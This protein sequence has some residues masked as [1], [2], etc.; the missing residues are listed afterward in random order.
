MA[1][2]LPRHV[3]WRPGKGDVTPYL[4]VD[5]GAEMILTGIATQGGHDIDGTA[6]HSNA[7]WVSK[8]RLSGSFDGVTW[9]DLASGVAGNVDADSA[10]H[11][12]LGLHALEQARARF[13]RLYPQACGALLLA[14]GQTTPTSYNVD[15]AGFMCALRLELFGY[16]VCSS[17]SFTTSSP[18]K[19]AV[20]GP[21]G[22]ENGALPDS[23]ITASS[24]LALVTPASAARLN[25]VQGFFK[26]GGWSPSCPVVDGA[27]AC[28]F[29]PTTSPP[30]YLQVDLGRELE[31][32]AVGT[33]GSS[34]RP[35][36][37]T[38]YFLAFSNDGKH[39]AQTAKEFV[40]NADAS[41]VVKLS[42]PRPVLARY[43]RIIPTAWSNPKEEYGLRWELYGPAGYQ[44]GET[45]CRL[46]Q[47][48]CPCADNSIA[49]AAKEAPGAKQHCGCAH[50]VV[51]LPANII[52]VPR[53][54]IA[55][56][57]EAPQL[58]GHA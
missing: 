1:H 2:E 7:L 31:I 11:R 35:T 56:T 44:P 16:P 5:L 54:I 18:C 55:E 50:T 49:I 4:E 46:Q 6:Q 23:S 3:G 38:Q 27:K 45:V 40:G 29:R 14:E 57:V 25:A 43:V 19:Q 20:G 37:V 15:K 13:V 52:A 42:L 9:D 41:Q 53:T 39:W 12:D 58:R 30:D 24:T 48:H 28:S 36:W 22:L 33:Q 21:L 32:N 51:S 34:S 17:T 10:A 47:P 26:E 8:Y